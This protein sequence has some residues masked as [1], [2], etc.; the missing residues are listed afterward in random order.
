MPRDAVLLRCE[1]VLL[2]AWWRHASIDTEAPH[3]WPGP[4]FLQPSP[5]PAPVDVWPLASRRRP[6]RIGTHELACK[7]K[8]IAHRCHGL[9]H[10]MA[11]AADRVWARAR[12]GGATRHRFVAFPRGFLFDRAG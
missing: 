3:S 7:L 1:L 8:T 12:P 11:G 9:R 5:S 4:E 6:C 2:L 10:R